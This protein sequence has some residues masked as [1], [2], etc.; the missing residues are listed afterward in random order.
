MYSLN[1]KKL[2]DGFTDRELLEFSI[3]KDNTIKLPQI[4]QH[5]YNFSFAKT[6]CKVVGWPTFLPVPVYHD[7]GISNIDWAVKDEINNKAKYFL[8]WS[9]HRKNIKIKGKKIIL[10]EHPYIYYKKNIYKNPITNIRKGTLV[11]LPHGSAGF[12]LSFNYKKFFNKLKKLS[13][14]FSPIVICV[15]SLDINP[16]YLRKIRKYKFPIITLGRCSNNNFVDTLYSTLSKFK[17]C[18]GTS[19]GSF[20]PLAHEMGLKVFI[21]KNKLRHYNID[22]KNFTI[23]SYVKN[24]FFVNKAN[25]VFD[26]K[27]LNKNQI[28]KDDLVSK[29]L[30]I[31]IKK[32]LF[33]IFFLEFLRL[34]P[35]YISVITKETIYFFINKLLKR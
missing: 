6:I 20:V 10:L 25:E 4:F 19:F 15:F 30:N 8:I 2:Y 24:T 21:L 33:K 13:K 23:N 35:Y 22:N 11:F 18:C 27:N 29:M 31:G 26:I 34:F 14:I 32:K 3:K 7:H 16:V 1:K 9:Q 12:R 17:Y 5:S 28:L